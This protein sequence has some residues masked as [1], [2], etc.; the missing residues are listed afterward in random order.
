M[1]SMLTSQQVAHFKTFGF[2]IIRG[3][4]SP[5]EMAMIKHESDEIFEE[6]RGGTPFL[7]EN[8]EAVQPFFERRPFMS[9]L[10][11]DDRIYGIATALCGPNFVL[12]GTEGNLHVGET[13][14]HSSKPEGLY[15][16]SAQGHSF[17]GYGEFSLPNVKITF[18]PEPTTMDTGCLRVVPGSHTAVSPDFLELLRTNN[19]DP[20]FRPFGVLPSEIPAYSFES[21][22]GDVMVFTESVIHA[23]FGGEKGRQQHAISFFADPRSKEEETLIRRLYERSKYSYRPAMSYIDSDSP[24]IRR[25]VSRLVEWGFSPLPF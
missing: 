21:Q 11:E 17:T 3:L 8:W 25:M 1:E 23:A 19:Q 20:E 2:L 10:A 4:F 6:E 13:A 5:D 15:K 12:D 14:W 9:G 7:G 16:T 18:Y 24:R 22:P